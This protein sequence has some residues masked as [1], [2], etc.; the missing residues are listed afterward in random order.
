MDPHGKIDMSKKNYHM[1]QKLGLGDR[2]IMGR[3]RWEDPNPVKYGGPTGYIALKN[4]NDTRFQANKKLQE[5]LDVLTGL[6]PKPKV[7]ETP[8]RKVLDMTYA[9]DFNHGNV[10][11]PS[12]RSVLVEPS[13]E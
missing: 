8:S 12:V 10:H 5:E 4:A 13:Y 2:S 9:S 6:K 1:Q 11:V 3:R 7:A